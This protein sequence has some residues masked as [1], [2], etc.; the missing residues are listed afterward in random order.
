M[1]RHLLLQNIDEGDEGDNDDN[2]QDTEIRDILQQKQQQQLQQQ[3][4]KQQ[5][6]QQYKK[7]NED[8]GSDRIFVSLASYRDPECS[9]TLVDLFL[10]ANDPS[11]I[12]VG[13]CQQNAPEDPDCIVD[14]LRPFEHQIRIVRLSHFDA[15]GPMY[16]RA[17]IEQTLY[18]GEL[19][20]M[21]IDSHMLFVKGW[22]DICIKQ[23][24]QCPSEKPLLTTYPNDF[25]RLTRK[26]VIL[27]DGSKH[28]IGTIP[29]TFIRFRDFHKR[30]KFSEQ[31]KQNFD[32][33]PQTPQPSLFWAAGFCFSL[34]ELIQ[35]VPYDPNCPFLFVGEEMGTAIRYFT[36]GWDFYAPGVNIVYHLL[37]RTYRKTFWEQVYRKN[38]VVD[39]DTR[40]NHKQMEEEAVIRTTNLIHGQ[41][42]LDDPYNIGHT[43]SIRD[44]EVFTGVN[45]REQ[46]AS[47]RS[48]QG[49]S[50]NASTF[51]K[52]VKQFNHRT[53]TSAVPTRPTSSTATTNKKQTKFR[54]PPPVFF[55]GKKI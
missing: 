1:D 19:F 12:Y 15:K 30:L 13:V 26:H 6:K 27:P 25:D 4:Q 39:D 2:K 14:S 48:Y 23:L 34:G 38:C 33:V 53:L 44:W 45:I 51:E 36:H 24:A 47:Q 52:R 22:D 54:R 28:P 16:A 7:G 42:P 10:K 21:Q 18:Q 5:Q 41:L 35:E 32:I 40:I 29:P 49:L 37:K 50:I 3:L 55:N 17:L 9:N 43:R 31:E 8:K 46:T 20:Y 11:R